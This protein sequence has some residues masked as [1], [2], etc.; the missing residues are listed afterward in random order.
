MIYI[1]TWDI[2]CLTVYEAYSS[3]SIIT[4]STMY[5][6][7]LCAGPAFGI[8]V[9]QYTEILIGMEGIFTH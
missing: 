9:N 4:Y 5:F 6:K 1:D 8:L 2:C 7:N 3:W